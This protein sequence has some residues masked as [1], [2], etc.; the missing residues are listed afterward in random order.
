MVRRETRERHPRSEMPSKTAAEPPKKIFRQVKPKP[1]P[2]AV[3]TARPSL[4]RPSR[5]DAEAEP[6]RE[7]PLAESE[8]P[9]PK[10]WNRVERNE[11]RDGARLGGFGSQCDRRRNRER[12][13]GRRRSAERPPCVACGRSSA[14]PTRSRHSKLSEPRRSA[15]VSKASC[16]LG[17]TIGEDGSY[18]TGFACSRRR[19]ITVLDDA[20]RD[21]VMRLPIPAPPKELGWREREIA[22]PVRFALD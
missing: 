18:P 19:A 21:S 22:L 7:D 4:R 3:R 10:A 13:G 1:K 11:S 9:S 5:E 17:I 20:A 2:R 8:R 16:G 6:P 15:W 14:K 12:I